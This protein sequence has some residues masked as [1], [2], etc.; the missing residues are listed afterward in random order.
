MQARSAY[1]DLVACGPAGSGPF[2]LVLYYPHSTIIE[3]FQDIDSAFG[4]IEHAEKGPSPDVVPDRQILEIPSDREL[5]LQYLREETWAG[6]A[7]H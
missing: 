1:W 2:R 7:R 5:A 3:Y 6:A 4:A